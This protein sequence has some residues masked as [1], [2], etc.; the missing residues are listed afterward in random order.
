MPLPS[1]PPPPQIGDRIGKN[2]VSIYNQ[3]A[4]DVKILLGDSISGLDTFVL[5]GLE[6]WS[7]PEYQS[8]PIVNIKTGSHSIGYTLTLGSSFLLFWNDDK[9]YWDIKKIKK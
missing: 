5:K 3:S 9:K 4:S 1:P 2:I 6:T 8:N 7:S